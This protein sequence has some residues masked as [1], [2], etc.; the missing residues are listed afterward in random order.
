MF[1]AVLY[2]P[3][4]SDHFHEFKQSMEITKMYANMDSYLQS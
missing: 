4:T 1:E 3:E 2:Y